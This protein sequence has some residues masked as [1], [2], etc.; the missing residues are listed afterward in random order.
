MRLSPEKREEK[1]RR[2]EDG[3][4]SLFCSS[5]SSSPF[6]CLFQLL[7]VFKQSPR[8]RPTYSSSLL[9]LLLRRK[10]PSLSFPFFPRSRRTDTGGGKKERAS[11]PPPS[12]LF[13]RRIKLNLCQV[14][15]RKREKEVF[16]RGNYVGRN[17]VGENGEIS[18]PFPVE[19]GMSPP[20]LLVSL[21]F[22]TMRGTLSCGGGG[23]RHATNATT[24]VQSASSSSSSSVD[25]VVLCQVRSQN[26]PS[27]TRKEASCPLPPPAPCLSTPPPIWRTKALQLLSLS[28]S[29]KLFLFFHET[30]SCRCCLSRQLPSL[31]PSTPLPS[32]PFFPLFS[33]RRTR[34]KKGKKERW[35]WRREFG[36]PTTGDVE[37][38][39]EEGRRQSKK[40]RRGK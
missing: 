20:F 39:G 31:P 10:F 29:K 35:R 28:P 19:V 30:R 8:L 2:G 22:A 16:L 5:S 13:L 40:K 18:S 27:C 34:G 4:F 36:M 32:P 21:F 24:A 15:R 26:Q 23:G 6:H 17:A 3:T 33:F 7:E 37:G 12:L 11:F 1:K 25:V 9:F 38:G 14:G